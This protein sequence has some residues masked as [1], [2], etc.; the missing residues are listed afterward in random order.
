MKS[1]IPYLEGLRAFAAFIVVLNHFAWSFYPATFTTVLDEVHTKN[2]VE[3][4]F[5]NTPLGFLLNGNLAVCIFF[6]LSGFVVS[7]K[8][9]QKPD[10]H[11]LQKSAIQRYFRLLPT[12]LFCNLLAYFLVLNNLNYN[13]SA[14][15]VTKSH[16]WLKAIWTFQPNFWDALTQS[17]AI[18]IPGYPQ[19][20]DTPLY[21]IPE[22][23]IGSLLC[24]AVLSLIGSMRRRYYLYIVLMII[25][26]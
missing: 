2:R 18:I 17:F 8:F 20:Y 14:S 19:T 10:I 9:F 5:F 21:V 13:Q 11:A 15:L 4:L 1:R 25:L 22:I 6:V 23:V 24:L 26:N 3:L 7:I 16:I 12:V